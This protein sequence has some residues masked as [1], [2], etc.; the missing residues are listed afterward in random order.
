[1][2][3]PVS[4]IYGWFD[5]WITEGAGSKIWYWSIPD[6]GMVYKLCNF[7][8]VSDPS[9]FE[10]ARVKVNDTIVWNEMTGYQNIW[11]PTYANAMTVVFPDVI[12]VALVQ[13]SS[14]PWVHYWEM[15]FWREQIH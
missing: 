13:V 4:P 11:R 3:V 6:D 15:D 10:Y 8:A 12:E 9:G 7:N 5:Q 2:P 1:M 14:N